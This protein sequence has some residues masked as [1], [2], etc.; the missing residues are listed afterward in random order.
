MAKSK[1]KPKRSLKR[2]V[3][4]AIF[5][6]IIILLLITIWI[7][8]RFY[9]Y[10]A[11][12]NYKDTMSGYA[13][14]TLAQM[15]LDY[16]EEAFDKTKKIYDS[17]PEEIRQDPFT[18]EYK[19]HF[20]H[21]LDDNY[22]DAREILVTCRE[23][24]GITNISYGFYDQDHERL[25]LVI[26]GD[27]A[28]YFYLPGQ[29]ISNDNGSID[30]WK[31]IEKIMYSKAY[32]SLS[33]TSLLGYTAS[34]YDPIYGKDGSL[35][36]VIAIDTSV[37]EFSDELTL[38]LILFVPAVLILFVLLSIFLSR[39]MDR[40]VVAPVRTLAQAAKA[41]TQMDKVNDDDNTSVFRDIELSST[42]EIAELQITM[43]DM[44]QNIN[45]S[46]HEIRRVSGEKERM[47]AEL[48]IA[49]QLQQ[50]ALPTDFSGHDNYDL[51]ASM[52]P[53]KEVAGDFY[54]FFMVDDDHMVM[55]IAD[56][57]GKGVPSAL[58]MMKGKELLRLRAEKGGTPS[59][60]LSY[61]NK[62]LAKGNDSAMFITIWL[63]ILEIS[64]GI[65]TAS[66][67][68]HEY[69]FIKCADGSFVM[70][71]DPHGL[72][73]GV[74]NGIKYKD[75]TVTIPKGGGLFLYTDG[76]AE[77]NNPQ[78]EQFGLGRIEKCLNSHSNVS[79]KEL[80][81]FM[82]KDIDDFAGLAEQYDDITMMCLFMK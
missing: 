46:M 56:V 37:I 75:Y 70:Y 22:Y 14:Y 12:R 50:S 64:T 29:Y 82:K 1:P 63:G 62:E 55:I 78:G 27:T 48:D 18:E 7:G 21:L 17:L 28:D 8:F 4:Q 3:L 57:S 71:E 77:A 9:L 25:V 73:C 16:I 11:L 45:E 66:S 65:I 54:D 53:A 10:V 23:S 40:K 41:Y 51:F 35:I 49:A 59:E 36:G 72:V 44:E 76:V 6:S 19:S 38:F 20:L 69:P 47:A 26:D 13:S 79:A 60:I 52:I 31:T 67:A 61:A 15:D 42:D 81:E 39:L 34:V 43:S 5:L 74:I 80:I 33:H 32:L 30:S 2:Q 58:F 24:T 68:G